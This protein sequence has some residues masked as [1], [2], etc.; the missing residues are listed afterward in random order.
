MSTPPTENTLSG[1][2]EPD[3]LSVVIPNWNGAHHLRTCLDALAR[4]THT[5]IEVIAVDNASHDESQALISG[6]Y[7]WVKLIVLPENRGFTGACNAG[8]IAARGEFIALLNN[9]TEVDVSWAATVVAAFGRN[10]Q[11]GSVASKMLLFDRRDHIHTTG[12]FFTLDGRAGNRGVWERDTGQYDQEAEVFSAC[13]GSSAYR[14]AML[15]EIGLLDD[16]FFFSGEDVDLGWRAQLRGWRCL[17]TPQAIVYHHLAATGGGVTASYYD[18]RNL[19]FILVK[20]YPAALWRKHGSAVLSAQRR[21][22]W[23]ALR[24]WRGEAARA[25]LRGMVAGIVGIPRMWPKRRAIQAGC[26]VSSAYL[27]SILTPPQ[28]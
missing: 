17:Y 18:G 9:D 14:R 28:S 23:E 8:M 4:Q 12:D 16:D 7:P 20:N 3:L 5:E 1:P 25:R 11:I 6:E 22:A 24:A 26:R 27:E 2:G 19:I 13:G 21:L 15:A 10:P